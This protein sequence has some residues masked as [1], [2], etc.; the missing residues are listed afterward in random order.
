MTESGKAS[1]AY[2]DGKGDVKNPLWSSIKL[3]K[4]QSSM[5]L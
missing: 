2:Q 4:I 3:L 1:N 5:Y